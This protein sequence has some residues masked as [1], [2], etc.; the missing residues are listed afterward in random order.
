[1]RYLGCI[2]WY[3]YSWSKSKLYSHLAIKWLIDNMFLIFVLK[4]HT[5]LYNNADIVSPC[6]M[7][8]VTLKYSDVKT[9][10]IIKFFGHISDYST[11]FM[12]SID[13]DKYCI[14]IYW[15]YL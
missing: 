9:F 13:D 4:V 7:P 2:N 5:E 6:L 11:G 1:M 12:V 14:L 3:V 15:M 10:V 8:L